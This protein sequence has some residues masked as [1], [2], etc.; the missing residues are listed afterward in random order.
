MTVIVGIRSGQAA[1][2][3]SDS[4]RISSQGLSKAPYDKTFKCR[5]FVGAHAGLV[6]F[7]GLD[8]KDHIANAVGGR[9]LLPCDG[10]RMI[11]AHVRPIL[12]TFDEDEVA[13]QYRS[14][15]IILASREHVASVRLFPN[16][17]LHQIE[18]TFNYNAAWLSAGADQAKA[19]VMRCLPKPNTFGSFRANMLREK[20]KATLESGIAVCEPSERNP[21]VPSCCGP[22]RLRDI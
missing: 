7:A 4:Q 18:A 17:E 15:D 5:S 2:A 10:V 11:D 16:L 9:R 20:F 8:L 13:F 19:E 12:Q 22:V 3:G 21:D 1:V 14:L 6:E